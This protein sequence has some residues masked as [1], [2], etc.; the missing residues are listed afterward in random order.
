MNP[1]IAPEEKAHTY[2]HSKKESDWEVPVKLCKKQIFVNR[3]Y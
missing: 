2:T 1:K 3:K